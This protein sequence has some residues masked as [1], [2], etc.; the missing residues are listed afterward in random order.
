MSGVSAPQL[1]VAVAGAAMVL[2]VLTWYVRREPDRFIRRVIV[3]ATGAKLL[4]T[5]AYY[6]VIRDV[7][8]VGDVTHYVLRGREIAPVIRSG[9]MPPEASETGTPFLEFLTGL[10]FAAFGDSEVVGYL[11][12]STL[13]FIGMLAFL[14]A[15]QLAVPHFDA[16]RYALLVLLLPTMLFWP[17]TIGKDAWLVFT[18]GVASYGVARVLTRRR[19]GYLVAGISV[20]GMAAVRPHMAALFV[21]SFALAYLLRLNDPLVKRSFVT[22]A[23]GLGLVFGGVGFI[24]STFSEEQGTGEVAEDVSAID[25]LLADTDEILE[26]TDQIT[27]RGGA[28]FESRPVESVGDYANALITVPF[29]PFVFEAH[30]R[31]AQLLGLES[32]LLMGLVIAATPRF[33]RGARTLLR[34]PYL[35]FTAIYTFGFIFAFANIAN[36]GI[37]SRQRSQLLPFLLVLLVVRPRPPGPEASLEVERDRETTPRLPVLAE[38]PAGSST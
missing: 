20:T 32:L 10:V 24:L 12:F 6:L 19:L 18:L 25:R 23:V 21:L 5:A 26:R 38:P 22:W 29:R 7:Y 37:L 1:G 31:Q 2:L 3:A 36:F 9:A 30:N 28:E 15:L 13:S 17:S 4:G 34:T 33:L 8:G 35:A 14:K 11:V 16:R 27:R